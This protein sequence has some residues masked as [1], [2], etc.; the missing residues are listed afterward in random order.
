MEMIVIE[1]TNS[2]SDKTRY[3]VVSS[4]FYD[5]DDSI[6]IELAS[7]ISNSFRTR[8]RAERALRKHEAQGAWS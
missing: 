6:A 3:R 4:N 7:V 2:F 1:E 5:E 8:R